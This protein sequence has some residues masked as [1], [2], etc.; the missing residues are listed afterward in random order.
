MPILG[1]LRQEE[2]E[3]LVSLGY[4]AEAYFPHQKRV[5]KLGTGGKGGRRDKCEVEKVDNGRRCRRQDK[6]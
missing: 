4:P 1:R 5:K 6:S 3:F 2:F